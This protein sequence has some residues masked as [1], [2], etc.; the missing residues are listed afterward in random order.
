MIRRDE[1][2]LTC[3]EFYPQSIEI[4]FNPHQIGGR[5]GITGSSPTLKAGATTKR[6]RA[7]QVVADG[8][9]IAS[10]SGA[11]KDT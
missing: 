1:S 3:K 11:S 7:R 2:I 9:D 5:G 8:G 4:F 6:G 10:A